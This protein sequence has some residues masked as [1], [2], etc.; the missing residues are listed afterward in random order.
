MLWCC[1]LALFEVEEVIL[2]LDEPELDPLVA[3]WY[4]V[5]EVPEAEEE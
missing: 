4:G 3:L 2:P 1:V 5:L